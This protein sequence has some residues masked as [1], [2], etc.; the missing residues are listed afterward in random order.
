MLKFIIALLILLAGSIA[1]G[2][3]RKVRGGS[4]L[5]PRDDGDDSPRTLEEISKA[6]RRKE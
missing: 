6:R 1:Y 5:P 3:Y 4:F 2:V